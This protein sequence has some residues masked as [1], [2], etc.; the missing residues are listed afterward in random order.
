[1]EVP[2][3]MKTAMARG[4]VAW[5]VARAQRV[6]FVYGMR[7]S[8]NH[9]CIRWLANALE[10]TET[11]FTETEF[12]GNFYI[13]DSR[14]T[15]FLNDI[16]SFN[17]SSYLECLR[18]NAKDLKRAA[19]VIISAEDCDGTYAQMWRVPKRSEVVHV[20][21]SSL[22]MI[23]S[24]FHNLNQLA[25]NGKALYQQSMDS[26]FFSVLQTNVASPAGAVW[27]F[28]K[29]SIDASWRRSFLQNLGLQF[30]AAPH[31]SDEGDGSSFSGMQMPSADRLQRR[32]AMVEPRDAWIAFIQGVAQRH[33]DIFEAAE[34]ATIRDL[35]N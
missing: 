17:G 10:N 14:R 28:E 33:A 31:I 21:R 2:H 18:R 1:M 5:A 11:S 22:N 26:K 19:F 6:F 3:V 20:R 4:Y 13:S 27:S 30:D 16:S 32:F 12:R 24:R 25:R 8:G 7:R 34:I 35:S 9:A 15:A 23:A 29:W